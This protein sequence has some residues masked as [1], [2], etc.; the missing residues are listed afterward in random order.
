MA[1]NFFENAQK[2]PGNFIL[3]FT[4]LFLFYILQNTSLQQIQ[5][6]LSILRQPAQQNFQTMSLGGKYISL[7]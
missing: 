3:K 1:L 5:A 4:Y 2:K 7:I 6:F